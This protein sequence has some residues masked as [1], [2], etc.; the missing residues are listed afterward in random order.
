MRRV[1]ID[2]NYGQVAASIENHYSSQPEL[3]PEGHPN[4]RACPQCQRPT[5][6]LTRHCLCCGVDLFAV[7]EQERRGRM[8]R[9]RMKIAGFFGLVSALAFYGQSHV[10]DAARIW[11]M[12]I[13]LVA[14]LFVTGLMKD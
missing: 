3:P 6:R 7:D 5:W 8:M 10:P 11:V 14:M 2:T 4:S 12:G 13:G 9:R 1:D